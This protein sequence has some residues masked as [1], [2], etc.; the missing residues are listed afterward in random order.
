MEYILSGKLTVRPWQV[1]LGRLVSTKHGLFSSNIEYIYINY[2]S[3]MFTDKF[4]WMNY[5]VPA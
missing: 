5:V 1:G 3:K 2:K 4:I